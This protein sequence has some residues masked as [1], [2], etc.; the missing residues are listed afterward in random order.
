MKTSRK[1][2]PLIASLFVVG[3]ALTASGFAQES[4]DSQST[5]ATAIPGV[6]PSFIVA[7]EPDPDGKVP[8]F[9]GVPGSGVSNIAVADPETVLT[10]GKNYVYTVFFEDYNVTGTYKVEYELTQVVGTTTKTLQ[11][12]TIV[13][14]KSFTPGTLWAW[15]IE[16]PAIPD[17]P[18][19][20]TL[21]GKIKYG[22]DYGTEATVKT[23]VLIQ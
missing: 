12:G 5:E 1:S 7:G 11:K 13:T 17:S 8:V 15:V 9:N 4:S 20:A 16:G 22:T 21:E 19:L 14:G 10:H 23:P 18:G 6:L 3:L 2:L